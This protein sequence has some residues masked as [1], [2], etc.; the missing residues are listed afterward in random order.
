MITHHII[1]RAG[2]AEGGYEGVRGGEGGGSKFGK[3]AAKL[4]KLAARSSTNT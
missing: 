3:E 2:R 4:V 1:T